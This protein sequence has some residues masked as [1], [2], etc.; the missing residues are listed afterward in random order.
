M[1]NVDWSAHFESGNALKSDDPPGEWDDFYQPFTSLGSYSINTLSA[2]FGNYG[3]KMYVEQDGFV[4][5]YL[6]STADTFSYG[7]GDVVHVA[8]YLRFNSG[9]WDPNTD[10]HCVLLAVGREDMG[11]V[12]AFYINEWANG[13]STIRLGGHAPQYQAIN[14]VTTIGFDKTYHIEGEILRDNPGY[15]K[16]YING[17]LDA[18]DLSADI[19][20]VDPWTAVRLEI[21]P[22]SS[23]T[24]ATAY[25]ID[26]IRIGNDGMIGPYAPSGEFDWDN[27]GPAIYTNTDSSFYADVGM[28]GG[29]AFLDSTDASIRAL[30]HSFAE[31]SYAVE[32]INDDGNYVR[33]YICN[34]QSESLGPEIVRDGSFAQ[35]N[36]DGPDPAGDLTEWEEVEGSVNTTSRTI[37]K[38][39]VVYN[40]SGP[41]TES[42]KITASGNDGSTDIR[43][44]QDSMSWPDTHDIIPNA[45]YRHSW[46]LY[47]ASGI[48][49]STRFRIIFGGGYNYKETY[50]TATTTGFEQY[51]IEG[52]FRRDERR[53]DIRIDALDTVDAVVYLDDFSTKRIESSNGVSICSYR[54]YGG[55]G[56]GY[57]EEIDGGK[58]WES[59]WQT[60][61]VP[62]AVRVYLLP[63]DHAP[64]YTWYEWVCCSGLRS[65]HYRFG[66]LIPSSNYAYDDV[67]RQFKALGYSNGGDDFVFGAPGLTDDS[68]TCAT[69]VVDA[70]PYCS[71]ADT[72]SN[73]F[74]YDTCSFEWFTNSM[75]DESGVATRP[76]FSKNGYIGI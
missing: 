31:G 63:V 8:F 16:L 9:E 62:Y 44:D 24:G 66:E 35:W 67:H 28:D 75:P 34:T 42:L 57:W 17:K 14:S 59:G 27:P 36:S 38:D 55:I 47:P 5:N 46:W 71:R 20:D 26:A 65:A 23:Q 51:L 6:V 15:F 1:A 37:E 69:F 73:F 21:D 39:T 70:T 61:E 19:G 12:Y 56:E 3:C 60:R 29:H 50:A 4:N 48:S 52:G 40:T 10:D 30:L 41:G 45:W 33:G 11:S 72:Y 22:D 13:S 74:N 53:G 58:Y 32:V 54:G 18:E 64:R 49:A 7:V 76:F 25:H 43:I 2:V 68:D